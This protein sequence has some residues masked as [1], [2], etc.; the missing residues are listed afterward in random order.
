VLVQ[1]QIAYDGSRER[2]ADIEA[3]RR[4]ERVQADRQQDDVWG[5]LGTLAGGRRGAP[6][7]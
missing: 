7:A 2:E 3:E 5:D 6:P 1:L 4:E